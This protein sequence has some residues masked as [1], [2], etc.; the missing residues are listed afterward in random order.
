[1]RHLGNLGFD[2]RELVGTLASGAQTRVIIRS[3]MT[4][5]IRLDV[6]QLLEGRESGVSSPSPG[7][8]K[9]MKPEIIVSVGGLEKSIAPYGRPTANYFMVMVG[10]T[11]AASL[12]GAAIAWRLCRG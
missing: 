10:G 1:M 4:P 11:V 2:A 6:A 7:Y 9:L 12:I 8:M 3:Q 5:E